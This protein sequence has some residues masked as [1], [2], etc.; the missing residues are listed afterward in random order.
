M[1]GGSSAVVNL[2]TFTV[3]WHFFH[4][5]NA[6]SVTAAYFVSVLVHFL[7]NRYITFRAMKHQP[8]WRNLKKYVV[9]VGINYLI[10][11]G[12]V[13]VGVKTFAL[14]PPIAAALAIIATVG[15]GFVLS[16]L[17]VFKHQEDI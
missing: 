9:M 4:W 3:C 1:V 13:H 10:S 2:A 11:L 12:V 6:M 5:P 8:L 16:K 7:G 14:Y 15:L 17:W